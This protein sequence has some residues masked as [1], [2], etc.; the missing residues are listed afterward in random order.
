MIGRKQPDEG[1]CE[2]TQS[3]THAHSMPSKRKVKAGPMDPRKTREP[4]TGHPTF[5]HYCGRKGHEEHE[6]R[7][8]FVRKSLQKCA[9]FTQ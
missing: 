3:Q 8:K 2:L 9:R 4:V 7:T 6:C 1:A 5:C